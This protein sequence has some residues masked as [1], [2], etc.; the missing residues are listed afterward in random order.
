MLAD[1]DEKIIAERVMAVLSAKHTLKPVEAPVTPVA[2]LSG[3]WE[4]EIKYTA[5]STTHKLVLQQN[6]NRLEGVHQ[7]NF[8]TRDVGGT[9]SGDA[10]TLASNVTERHGDSLNYRFTG[11]VSGDTLSGTLSLG[12]Y[13]SA[14]WTAKRPAAAT[15]RNTA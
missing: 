7:G 15:N 13:R 5:S 3:Q 2:N 4:V 12:E 6:G 14:T 11:K 10:V 9:I 8:L 1:G